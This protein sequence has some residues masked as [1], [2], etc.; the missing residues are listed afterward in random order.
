MGTDTDDHVFCAAAG[1]QKISWLGLSE[2]TESNDGMNC[3]YNLNLFQPSSAPTLAPSF[4]PIEPFNCQDHSNP[5]QVL[6][7]DDDSDTYSVAELTIETGEYSLLWDIDWFD[8]HVNAVGLY[9]GNADDPDYYA[10]GSF[11]GYLCGFDSVRKECFST[12]LEEE[13]PNIGAILGENYYYAKD[14]GRDGEK[15]FYWVE[16]ILSDSPVF[17]DDYSFTIKEDLYTEAV[18]DVA[19]AGEAIVEVIADGEDGR[20]Y[21]I[22]I[23]EQFEILVVRL[24]EDG[25]PEAYAVL[26]SEVKWLEAPKTTTDD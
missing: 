14:I 22:G 16:G 13:K 17:H 23:A 26:G 12:P 7:F 8:G 10:W 5:I 24:A 11:G 21:L 6:K 1:E 25:S 4:S 2:D 3:P 20:S 9:L 18:L 15:P 19:I